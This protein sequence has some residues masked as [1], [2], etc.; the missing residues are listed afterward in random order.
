MDVTALLDAYR[1]RVA[2][3][4]EDKNRVYAL[5]HDVYCREL[6]FEPVDV[7][8]GIEKDAF[9]ESAIHCLVEHR[10]SATDVGCARLVLPSSDCRSPL[11]RMPIETRYGDIF[12]SPSQSPACFPRHEICEISRVAIIGP[13]RSLKKGAD[14][15][16]PPTL[17]PLLRMGIFLSVLALGRV[18]G[19]RHGFALM[20]PSL[21]RLLTFAGFRFDRISR[22]I[23]FNGRRAVYYADWQR[24]TAG[25]GGSFDRT[26]QE[27]LEE[28]RQQLDGAVE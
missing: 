19:R 4:D 3:D 8:Q 11:Y 10:A 12:D 28:F 20:E 27:I 16:R 6:G 5:R 14:A 22:D 13:Y 15:G 26:Y 21:P 1:F 23:H 2:F 18:T 9:D 7:A 17:N 24:A 25:L